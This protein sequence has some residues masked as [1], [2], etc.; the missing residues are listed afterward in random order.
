LTQHINSIEEE[1]VSLRHEMIDDV[2]D[3]SFN[4]IPS[5]GDVRSPFNK[6]ES[7]K[8]SSQVKV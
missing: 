2:D 5:E 4:G 3:I 7:G 8:N 1:D 6:N